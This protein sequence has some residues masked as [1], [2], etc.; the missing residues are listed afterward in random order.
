MDTNSQFA[1]PLAAPELQGPPAGR[2]WPKGKCTP[3][4]RRVLAKARQAGC[5]R[6]AGIYA[7]V[8]QESSADLPGFDMQV[9]I[10]RCI[11]EGWLAAGVAFNTYVLTEAGAR[12]LDAP[13]A[14]EEDG[15]NA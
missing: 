11:A 6:R 8:P 5:V 2:P 4:L 1:L 3:T 13:A 7:D 14:E 10:D 9:A 12:V 15:R